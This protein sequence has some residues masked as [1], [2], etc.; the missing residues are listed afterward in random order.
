[1]ENLLSLDGLWNSVLG[2]ETTAEKIAKAKAKIVLSVDEAL[3]IHV[4]KATTAEEAWKNLHKTFEDTG[5]TRKVGLL[6]K[7]TTIGLKNC[8]SMEKYVNEIMS[9]AHQLTAIG[10]EINQEW[11]GTVLLADLPEQYQPMIMALEN[12]RM[13]ITVS[14]K[15]K[16]L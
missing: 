16:L 9:A 10:I 11:L 3:Y 5:V 2:T 8:E 7:I 12:S 14:V 1:M 4:A 13:A 15:T 6:R